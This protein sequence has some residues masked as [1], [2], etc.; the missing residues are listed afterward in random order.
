MQEHTHTNAQK[1]QA[2]TIHGQ[3]DRRS[4]DFVAEDASVYQD[5]I[6]ANTDVCPDLNSYN[7]VSIA[8]GDGT[9]VDRLYDAF[10][11]AGNQV[12]DKAPTLDTNLKYIFR[13]PRTWFVSTPML[14][15]VQVQHFCTS[16]F[17]KPFSV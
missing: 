13:N 7:P 10:P 11:N 15:S 1:T 17:N 14:Y 16:A 8:V 2:R 9:L 12:K 6:A 4:V 3:F 5:R